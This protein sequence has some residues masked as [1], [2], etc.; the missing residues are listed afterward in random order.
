[1][2]VYV[3]GLLIYGGGI[4]MLRLSA[5]AAAVAAAAKN[6]SLLPVWCLLWMLG[7]GAMVHGVD[8]YCGR[9]TCRRCN[10]Y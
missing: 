1:M 8:P 4:W 2:S 10:S 9:R 7:V 6:T 5:A 3:A